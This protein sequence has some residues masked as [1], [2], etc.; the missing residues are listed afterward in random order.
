[1]VENL[2]LNDETDSLVWCY[3]KSGVYS[4]KSLYAI[5]NYKRVKPVY[6]PAVWKVVV[7]PKIQ[8]FLWLL[9]HNK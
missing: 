3:N 1:V 6:V 5:I 4:T 2:V 7:P 9:S 8:L